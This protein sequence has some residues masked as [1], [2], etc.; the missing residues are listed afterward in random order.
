MTKTLFITPLV[1]VAVTA[2]FTFGQ[3]G[4]PA[5]PVFGNVA[6]GSL[7]ASVNTAIQ[8]LYTGKADVGACPSGQAMVSAST[9]FSAG[10]NCQQP[11]PHGTTLPGTCSVGDSFLYTRFIPAQLQSCIAT[12]TWAPPL[13]SVTFN[14]IPLFNPHF[15]PQISQALV[16]G[17]NDLYIAP[18]C[19]IGLGCNRHMIGVVVYSPAGA[20]GLTI[21]AQ[22][23]LKI[24]SSYFPMTIVGNGPAPG[25]SPSNFGEFILDPGVGFSINVANGIS[26][27]AYFAYVEAVDFD[28]TTPFRTVALTAPQHGSNL[29]YTVPA[30]HAATLPL[31]AQ[32]VFSGPANLPI[33]S[34]YWGAEA[35]TGATQSF[36]LAPTGSSLANAT[37]IGVITAAGGAQ[38]ITMIFP[39][40]LPAGYS[41]YDVLDDPSHAYNSTTGTIRI[42][43]YDF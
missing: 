30:G 23:Q 42:S 29:F 11:I 28:S 40:Y 5:P 1:L 15:N 25:G 17:E 10:T 16:Q 4:L 9:V 36:Y 19:S 27:N 3:S 43:V 26:A 32:S 20:T 24:G 8:N 39:G 33:L 2:V 18:S 6:F 41:V 21:S 14:G 37:L 31:T 35:P 38:S 34:I 22:V 13:S 12:N 7:R